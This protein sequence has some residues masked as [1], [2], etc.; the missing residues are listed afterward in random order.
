MPTSLPPFTGRELSGQKGTHS[1]QWRHFSSSST[2]VL[3]RQAP[4]LTYW[5][6]AGS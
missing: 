1:R 5:E 2:G 3:V 4:V 6:V